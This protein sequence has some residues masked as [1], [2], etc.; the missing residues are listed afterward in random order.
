MNYAR[1]GDSIIKKLEVD[2]E[3]AESCLSKLTPCTPIPK[4]GRGSSRQVR[5]GPRDEPV[6]EVLLQFWRVDRDG[7]EV[8]SSIKQICHGRP[9]V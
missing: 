2:E 3:E 5:D 4:V 7:I 1:T 8:P 9:R 6:E